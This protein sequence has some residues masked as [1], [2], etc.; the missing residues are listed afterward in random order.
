MDMNSPISSGTQ[1]DGLLDQ[2]Q[3]SPLPE[4]NAAQADVLNHDIKL[5]AA[6]PVQVS[7]ELG[8]TR[9]PIGQLLQ[10][11]PGAMIELD[12]AADQALRIFA[13]GCL[14][15]TGEVVLVKQKL[16]IRITEII[17]SNANTQPN[18]ITQTSSNQQ[19]EAPS[20]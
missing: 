11:A 14:I 5:I 9:M 19:A 1:A 12:G 13:N 8:R 3:A 18:L 20:A 2:K 6:I 16:G 10:L 15:A 4:I 17:A 7:V